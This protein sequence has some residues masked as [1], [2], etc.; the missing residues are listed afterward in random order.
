MITHHAEMARSLAAELRLPAEV[1][2]ALGAAYE[3]WDGKGWPGRQSGDAIP[4]AARLAQFAE[5]VEVAHRT[6]GVAAAR[7]LARR[8]G[9]RQFDPALA[10]LVEDDGLLADLDVA[11]WDAVI[12][13]EP[14]LA[15][16]LSGGDIEAALVA[17][18]DFVDLK[19]PVRARPC[20]RGGRAG[21]RRGG[22]DRAAGATTRARCAAR[23]SCT[24]SGGSASPTRSGTSRG[25]SARAS[26]SGCGCSPT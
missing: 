18:A 5:H 22:A 11:T 15:V 19:T 21:G 3:Q 12:D 7:E 24:T 4:H 14:A 16:V 26:G 1:M 13:A 2:D 10:A 6:G 20:P 17:V 8:R 23:R 25:R 9:G